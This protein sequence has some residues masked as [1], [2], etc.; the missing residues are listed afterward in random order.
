MG[1]VTYQAALLY[2]SRLADITLRGVGPY[3]STH[4]SKCERELQD[5]NKKSVPSRPLQQVTYLA[6]QRDEPGIQLWWG[7]LVLAV[8][9]R[10]VALLQDVG[11]LGDEIVE[12]AVTAETSNG[13][14]LET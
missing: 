7:C 8:D 11:Q 1:H 2:I 4:R 5:T 9:A 6:T 12:D 3:L 14:R 13:T 10:A